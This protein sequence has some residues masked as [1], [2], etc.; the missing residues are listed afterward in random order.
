MAEIPLQPPLL[1]DQEKAR[2]TN[3][4]ST[5]E[6]VAKEM[7]SEVWHDVKQIAPG[8]IREAAKDINNTL[9]QVFFGQQAGPGEPGTPLVPTQQEVYDQKHTEVSELELGQ[10]SSPLAQIRAQAHQAA[11]AAGPNKGKQQELQTGD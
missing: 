1:S 8:V 6:K 5:L 2:I 4:P 9:H 3:L 10:M 11:K 7:G